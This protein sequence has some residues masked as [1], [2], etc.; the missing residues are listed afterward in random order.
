MVYIGTMRL[1]IMPLQYNFIRSIF[2]YDL[3]SPQTANMKIFSIFMLVCLGCCF[4]LPLT[5]QTDGIDPV[6]ITRMTVD[7][8]ISD[9][10]SNETLYTSDRT[11]L[12]AM[13]EKRL[14]PRFNF[15]VMTQLAVGKYWSQASTEQKAS[16]VREFQ[17]LLV[18]TYSNMLFSNIKKLYSNRNETATV[19]TSTVTP[20]G[21][22]TVEVELDSQ[23]SEPVSVVLRMRRDGADWKVIDV[24]FN[25]IS[26]IVNYRA[27]FVR[28]IGL[29]GLDGM[30][31]SLTN[32]N[33][34]NR[35]E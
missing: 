29:S 18:R 22:A 26:L 11:Q 4:A 15:T 14:L 32:K 5:A 24:S 35:I 1:M 8:I 21:D 9:M 10:R 34:A 27:S 25:G 7:E 13:V 19:G 3:R 2:P 31:A 20:N 6:A 12:D 30:I 16:L 23:T 28:E 17:T 33:L